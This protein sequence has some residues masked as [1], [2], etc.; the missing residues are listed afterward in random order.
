MLRS[1]RRTIHKAQPDS[2]SWAVNRIRLLL[3]CVSGVPPFVVVTP[4]AAA[5]LSGGLERLLEL[6]SRCIGASSLAH[7]RTS[8]DQHRCHTQ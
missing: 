2:G 5:F 4:A 8:S 6:L 3:G 1:S 7:T